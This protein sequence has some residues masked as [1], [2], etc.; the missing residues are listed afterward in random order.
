MTRHADARGA[1]RRGNDNSD[2]GYGAANDAP[3]RPRT[4]HPPATIQQIAAAIRMAQA[5]G[6]CAV[7]GGPM[8]GNGATCLQPACIS[9]W[10]LGR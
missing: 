7:C 5:S 9:R 1:S 10:V 2:L 4:Y 6:K 3:P 8:S